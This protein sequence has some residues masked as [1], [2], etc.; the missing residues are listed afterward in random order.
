MNTYEQI[1][2]EVS[3]KNKYLLWYTDLMTRARSRASSKSSAREMLGY[4]ESHHILPRSFDLGGESNPDNLAHLTA[5]EHIL[6]HQLLIKFSTGSRLISS[7]RAFHCMCFRNNGGKNK[8][9]PTSKNLAEAR[10][11]ARIANSGPRGIKGLPSWSR[12]QDIEELKADLLSCVE[13]DLTDR[14]IGERF[15]ISHVA[16]NNWRIKLVVPNRRA[17]L[18]TPETLRHLY[19]DK[20][21]SA[22]EIA[23]LIG[24]SSAAVQQYLKR[25]NIPVRDAITRQRL[26]KIPLS[27]RGV[28]IHQ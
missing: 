1:L 24:C 6:A 10:N 25:F 21:L 26:K 11:A 9:F 19:V 4:V 23:S 22:G 28:Y 8:R 13:D 5:R 16:V 18:R 7:L 27:A 20:L 3:I 14:E 15:G 12:H 17:T 2:R